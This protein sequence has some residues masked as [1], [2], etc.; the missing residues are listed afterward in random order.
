MSPPARRFLVASAFFLVLGLLLH[1]LA[2]FD[3]W[4][5]FNPFAITTDGAMR[6]ALLIGWLGQLGLALAYDRWLP[7]SPGAMRVF[8]LLNAG[9]ILGIAGQPGLAVILRFIL[10]GQP[11]LASPLAAGLG[12]GASLGGL[13][14]LAAG[15]VF[16]WEV[17]RRFPP[18]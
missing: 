9:L 13:L 1:A 6:Q 17:W 12:M 16:A 10:P 15:G 2:L 14:Q 18:A 5:G 7:G 8:W 3:A 4:L 11:G